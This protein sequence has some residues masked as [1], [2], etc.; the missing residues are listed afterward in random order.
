MRYFTSNFGTCTVQLATIAMNCNNKTPVRWA[1]S[2]N[3]PP[4]DMDSGKDVGN[5]RTCSYLHSRAFVIHSH[6]M[7]KTSD[8]AALRSVQ[9]RMRIWLQLL[10]LAR[11]PRL[12]TGK[13]PL[14]YFPL[15]LCWFLPSFFRKLLLICLF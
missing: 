8:P 12:L 1:F 7:N 14:F 10:Q 11:K 13:K 15:G 4:G 6:I 3:M 5:P 9:G 2:E